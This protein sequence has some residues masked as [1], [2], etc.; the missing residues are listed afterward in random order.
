MKERALVMPRKCLV[1]LAILL[2]AIGASS[3]S[4]ADLA[5]F[6][7]GE[8][9]HATHVTE[10]N[11]VYH[12]EVLAAGANERRA[13][14]KLASKKGA[15]LLVTFWSRSC[16]RC[17]ITMRR[18]LDV[19]ERMGKHRV[20]AIAI[21]MDENLPFAVV[22]QELVRRDMQALAPYQ[23][24]GRRAALNF[25]SGPARNT[26]LYPDPSTIVVDRGGTVRLVANGLTDWTAPEAKAL[27]EE[28]AA[29]KAP[30][31]PSGGGSM[32]VNSVEA[33]DTG[34]ASTSLANLND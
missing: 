11:S 14:T 9:R 1:I 10:N 3:A 33:H 26:V 4:A 2:S 24:F 19:Q 7:T 32:A 27:L 22:R 31:I 12:I 17:R 15:V 30:L 23:D 25:F 34:I 13:V 6:L 28:L 5:P 20:E 21:N 18:L 16:E 29:D 8:L